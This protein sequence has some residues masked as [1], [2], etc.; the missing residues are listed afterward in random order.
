MANSSP[1]AQRADNNWTVKQAYILAL[2]CLVLGLATGYFLRGSGESAAAKP[3]AA[4]SAPAVSAQDM[5]GGPPSAERMKHMADEQAKPLLAQLGNEPGNPE[6]LAKIGNIYYDTQQ[7]QEA[8]NYYDRSLKVDPKSADVRTDRATAYFYLGDTDRAITE[9]ESVV[10]TDPKHAQTMFN[11]GMIKWQAKGDAKGAVQ[12]WEQL[13]KAVPDYPDRGKVEQLIARAK[14][15]TKI[16]PG[17][18]TD[19]PAS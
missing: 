18:K 3:T 5:Q 12:S 19:K 8:I 17:T 9:L 14:Q 6:L 7:F 2:I 10:K 1:Q 16:P 15:H 13:L 4:K 11:L